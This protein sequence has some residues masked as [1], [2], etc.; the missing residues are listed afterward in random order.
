MVVARGRLRRPDPSPSPAQILLRD[1]EECY[2]EMDAD[3]NW[4]PYLDSLF[5]NLETGAITSCDI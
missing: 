2:R 3:P 1:I 5:E 4:V